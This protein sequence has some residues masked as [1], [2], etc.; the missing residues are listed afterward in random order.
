[1]DAHGHEAA[2]VHGDGPALDRAAGHGVGDAVASE[3]RDATLV[4]PG[5]ALGME[6]REAHLHRA[7]RALGPAAGVAAGGDEQHVALLDAQARRLLGAH[8]LVGT[9]RLAG[10]EPLDPAK[11]RHVEQDAAAD[12]AVARSHDAVALRADALHVPGVEAVVHP[13]RHHHVAEGVDVG[14]GHAVERHAHVVHRGLETRNELAGRVAGDEHHVLRGVG[15]LGGGRDGKLV[16]AAHGGPV[17]HERGRRR[18]LLVGDVVEGPALVV[19]APPSPVLHVLEHTLDPRTIHG[20]V[21]PRARPRGAY[22]AAPP[23][24]QASAAGACG[25]GRLVPATRLRSE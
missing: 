2:L 6:P 17:A 23:T 4:E 12:D 25:S 10:L 7:P 15:V 11:P 24:G 18:A 5:D 3:H 9:D 22:D 14:D 13:P 19:G 16:G 20:L 21:L 8:Q 1:V